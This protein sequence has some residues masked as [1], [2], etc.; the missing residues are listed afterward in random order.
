MWSRDRRR[1][2]LGELIQMQTSP[3]LGFIQNVEDFLLD[4]TGTEQA[5]GVLIGQRNNL[6]H[7][8]F[9]CG[10]GFRIPNLELSI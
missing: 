6:I 10:G 5:Q 2:K 7:E 4:P 8:P 9:D 1:W 3:G